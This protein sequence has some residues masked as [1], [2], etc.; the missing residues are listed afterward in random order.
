MPTG[1]RDGVFSLSGPVFEHLVVE[2]FW[3]I[4]CITIA[5]GAA[6]HW[7]FVER[8]VSQIMN[9]CEYLYTMECCSYEFQNEMAKKL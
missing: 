6:F 4:K 3:D 1:V 8:M 7:T 2:K 5:S 9:I